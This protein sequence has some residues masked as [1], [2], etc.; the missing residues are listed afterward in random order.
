MLIF[1]NYKYKSAGC[2]IIYDFL[3]SCIENIKLAACAIP[4]HAQEDAMH[5]HRLLF[6]DDLHMLYYLAFHISK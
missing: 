1:F 2:W 3:Q 5:G 4:A 6:G